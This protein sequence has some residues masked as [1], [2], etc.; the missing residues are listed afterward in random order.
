MFQCSNRSKTCVVK[1]PNNRKWSR[2]K[3]SNPLTRELRL[4]H[5]GRLCLVVF[6]AGLA[7]RGV[8]RGQDLP[9]GAPVHPQESAEP[10][11]EAIATPAL[12]PISSDHPSDTRMF[13]VV[14][15]YRA[16][17]DPNHPIEPLTKGEKFIMASHDA[18]DPFTWV[19]TGLYAGVAQR[20]NQYPEFGQ[21]S[22]G[23]AKRYGG[24]FADGA[25]G[26]YLS[27][28]ILPSLLHEDPRYFRLGEGTKFHRIGY[29][30]SRTLITRTDSGGRRFNVSEIAGN[31]GAAGLS[32]LYYPPSNRSLEGTFEKFAVNV[33]S[34]A[35]FNVLKEFYPDMRHKLLHK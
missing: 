33:V 1:C 2:R 14:P 5:M 9:I 19:I 35:G 17:N 7:S 29:A 34:D 18:F 30:L 16:V 3:L 8:T 25:I 6:V 10:A 22:Q 31:L 32:N 13:G 15:N 28:A 12:P 20:Q 26:S 27:E 24:A 21:G 4:L 23:Y 11:P